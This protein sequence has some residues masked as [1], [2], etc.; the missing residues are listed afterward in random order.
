MLVTGPLEAVL[1]GF[2]K[3]VYKQKKIFTNPIV[4]RRTQ[5]IFG[6]STP[7][8]FVSLARCCYKLQHTFLTEI[9]IR[10]FVSVKFTTVF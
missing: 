7:M 3:N 8:V 1:Y 4:L 2:E 9:K 6:A 10:H 5:L